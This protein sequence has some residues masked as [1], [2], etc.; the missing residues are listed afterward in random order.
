MKNGSKEYVL[1]VL[2]TF[3]LS[4]KFTNVKDVDNTPP[5]SDVL[6]IRISDHIHAIVYRKETNSDLY[7]HWHAFAPISWK[8]R[9]LRMLVLHRMIT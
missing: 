9:T 4:T 2:E 3:H 5:F 7:L 6:F 8:R 1:S